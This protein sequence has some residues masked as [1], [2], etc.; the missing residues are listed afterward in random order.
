MCREAAGRAAF[1]A[2]ATDAFKLHCRPLGSLLKVR[3]GWMGQGAENQG[4]GLR[5]FVPGLLGRARFCIGYRAPHLDAL[6]HPFP[7]GPMLLPPWLLQVPQQCGAFLRLVSARGP[8]AP[9]WRPQPDRFPLRPLAG[10]ASGCGYVA[11]GDRI[12]LHCMQLR[13]IWVAW[14]QPAL[15]TPR[16]IVCLPC[17]PLIPCCFACLLAGGYCGSCSAHRQSRAWRPL[18]PCPSLHQQC[19]S[20]RRRQQQQSG[21]CQQCGTQLWCA[22]AAQRAQGRR[23][24]MAVPP[25]SWCCT[26]G[27]TVA[28]A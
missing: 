13:S 23:L 6:P 10:S 5:R 27:A 16:C 24:S 25:C 2:G 8:G 28:S 11:G 4:C 7:D 15:W 3:L 26:V 18:L 21:W 20:Q 14:Q 12:A 1:A 9:R 17:M 22:P 19:S